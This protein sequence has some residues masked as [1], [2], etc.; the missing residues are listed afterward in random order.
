[1]L[2]L[3]MALQW[4]NPGYSRNFLILVILLF[5][6]LHRHLTFP[7]VY[8]DPQALAQRKKSYLLLP[9]VFLGVTLVALAQ[10]SFF[11]GLVVLSVLWTIYHTVMQKL[12]ILRFYSRKA[13]YGLARIDRAILVSWFFTMV[14]FLASSPKVRGQAAGYAVSGEV[15]KNFFESIALIL[16]YLLTVSLVISLIATFLYLREEWR[17]RDQI[18]WPRNLYVLS[19]LAI[20]AVFP[21]DLL[22]GFA[23]FG[24]SHSIEYLAFVNV[25][26]RKKFQTLPDSS[27]FMARAVRRQALSFGI[28]CL[29]GGLLFLVWHNVSLKTLNIYIVGSSFLHFLYDG[30]IWKVRKPKVGEPLGIQYATANS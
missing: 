6:F 10:P 13:G 7:L 4:G 3:F 1:M 9:L 20:Y 21:Y 12:G 2:A 25:Y 29:V 17:H 27:S 28:F 11:R 18:S 22:V 14:L 24:F 23:I 30:W 19:I 15:L 26:A 8:G 5:N 16:P